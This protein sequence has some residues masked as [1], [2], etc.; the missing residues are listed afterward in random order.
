MM[1]DPIASKNIPATRWFSSDAS[2]S[3]STDCAVTSCCCNWDTTAITDG[4]NNENTSNT[5][6]SRVREA[7]KEVNRCGMNS[8]LS[9]PPAYFQ[10]EG[11]KFSSRPS[12]VSA[13]RLERKSWDHAVR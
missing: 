10:S 8:L 5:R 3:G 4:V 12:Y 11:K 1:H 2:L 13:A 6:Q 7:L 9:S